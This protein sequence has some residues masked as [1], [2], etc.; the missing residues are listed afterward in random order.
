[1]GSADE[2]SLGVLAGAL[3]ELDRLLAV[4]ILVAIRSYVDAERRLIELDERAGQNVG[5]RA[6]RLA[7][8]E[9]FGVTL[10]AEPGV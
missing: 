5:Y 4:A 3:A 1:M 9:S 7:R 10:E 6:A 8:L 2:P